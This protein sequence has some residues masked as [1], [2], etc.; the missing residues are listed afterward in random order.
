[1]LPTTF[2]GNQKQPLIIRILI[3]SRFGEGSGIPPFSKLAEA[4]M[5]DVARDQRWGRVAEGGGEKKGGQSEDMGTVLLRYCIGT[6]CYIYIYYRLYIRG[7]IY[8]I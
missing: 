5:V 2:Y 6:R 1:M 4:P 7:V 8:H 3:N